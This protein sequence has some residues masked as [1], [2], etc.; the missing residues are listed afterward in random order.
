[1]LS[2]P[3]RFSV[4]VRHPTIILYLKKKQEKIDNLNNI[5]NITRIACATKELKKEEHE[6]KK[7]K[8]VRFSLF[9]LPLSLA[10]VSCH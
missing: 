3:F 10:C 9:F 1:M 7:R 5:K 4:V 6:K 8:P 2:F